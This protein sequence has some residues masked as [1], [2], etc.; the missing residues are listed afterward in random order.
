MAETTET[1]IWYASK[2]LWVNFLAIVAM[3]LQGVTGHVVI[4][5]ELQGMA[6][7]LINMI[8]RIVTKKEIVWS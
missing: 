2:M 3:V 6:L 1:T 5:L 8:L 4:N 7:G